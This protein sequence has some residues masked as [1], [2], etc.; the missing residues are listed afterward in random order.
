MGC[1]HPFI[2]GDNYGKTCKWCGAT[3]G[4]YGSFGEGSRTC[5][6]GG[7]MPCGPGGGEGEG[8]EICVYCEEIRPAETA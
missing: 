3:V 4:G 7:W 6:H 5:Q 2:V 1:T 8:Y